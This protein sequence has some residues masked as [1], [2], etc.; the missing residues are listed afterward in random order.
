MNVVLWVV[1]RYIRSCVTRVSWNMI[2]KENKKSQTYI[3]HEQG[4]KILLEIWFQS[5][6]GFPFSVRCCG[7]FCNILAYDSSNWRMLFFTIIF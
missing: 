5:L 6:L 2:R 3:G 1:K 7:Y 4:E